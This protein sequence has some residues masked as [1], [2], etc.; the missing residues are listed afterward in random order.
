MSIG[1]AFI[2]DSGLIP[3][4]ATGVQGPL[5][6]YAPPSTAPGDRHRGADRANLQLGVHP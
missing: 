3:I 6:Y 5:L 1:R 4:S 2:T